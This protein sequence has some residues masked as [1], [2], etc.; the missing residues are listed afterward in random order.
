MYIEGSDKE[1]LRTTS[2]LFFF[3]QSSRIVTNKD[4]AYFLTFSFFL[5]RRAT[6]SKARKYLRDRWKIS[7]KTQTA[8]EEEGGGC[9]GSIEK[10]SK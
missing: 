5:P 6:L 2:F 3:T 10:R 7:R 9:R 1:N 4:R 8:Q